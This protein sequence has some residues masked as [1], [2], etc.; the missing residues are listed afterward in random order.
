MFM[1]VREISPYTAPDQLLGVFTTQTAA[2][3]AMRT[4]LAEVAE[5]DPWRGQ[6]FREVDPV[7]DVRIEAID[8]RRC[9]RDGGVAYVLTDF[10]EGLGQVSVRFL[11]VYSDAD[12]ARAVAAALEQSDHA[13][14]AAVALD[15]PHWKDPARDNDHGA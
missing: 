1:L 10:R 9:D 12:E 2:Q 4:Y 15:G 3:Q 14:V 7:Q 5:H 6:A 8:D 13:Y 11:A